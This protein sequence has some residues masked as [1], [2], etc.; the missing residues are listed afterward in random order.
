MIIR[1]VSFLINVEGMVSSNLSTR[2]LYLYIADDHRYKHPGKR[3]L[4][5]VSKKR[6]WNLYSQIPVKL[7]RD[8][9]HML[10]HK[11]K[12]VSG[13]SKNRLLGEHF[14]QIFLVKKVIKNFLMTFS[15]EPAV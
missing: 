8:F 12:T 1:V 5:E 3:T 9:R 7:F 13:D 4:K 14:K 6:F 10:G 11:F 15:L 2:F